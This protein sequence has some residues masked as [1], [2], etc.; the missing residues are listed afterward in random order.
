[1][2]NID[3]DLHSA[4]PIRQRSDK[5]FMSREI[6]D[7]AFNLSQEI[8]RVNEPGGCRIRPTTQMPRKGPPGTGKGGWT[9]VARGEYAIPAATIVAGLSSTNRELILHPTIETGEYRTR[10]PVHTNRRDANLRG[11]CTSIPLRESVEG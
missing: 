5:E 10:D 7:V 11:I 6:E 1:M 9:Y 4:F 8:S 2:P 3:T